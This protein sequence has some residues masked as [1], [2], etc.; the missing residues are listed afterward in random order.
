MSNCLICTLETASDTEYHP[1]CAKKLFES[2][3]VPEIHYNLSDLHKL[4]SQ[5]VKQKVTIPGVQAKMSMEIQKQA[6]RHAKMTIT[7][8]W[9]RFILKPPSDRWDQLPENE[10]C[11][12]SLAA[13]AG[14]DTVPFGLIRLLSGELSFISRRIDRGADGKKIAMEDMCQLTQRLTEDKYKGSQEQIA[15]VINQYSANPGFDLTRY[16]EL[17]LFCYLTGNGD[18]HLKNFSMINDLK[19]GWKLAEAYDLLNTRLVIPAKVDPEE[20]ALTIAGKKNNF[21]HYVFTVFGQKIGLN[22]KQ[23]NNAILNLRKK[24]PTLKKVINKSFLSTEMKSQYL[25]VITQR[26]SGLFDSGLNI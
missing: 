2:N 8:L 25:S 13:A 7:G 18:M 17:V 1:K 21:N 9:G 6:D 10:H 12:L 24:I 22:D 23:V 11:T 15:R 19:V 5:I 4:A 20:L 3:T 14:I 16:Y 26:S